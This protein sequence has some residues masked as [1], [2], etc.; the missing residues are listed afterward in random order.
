METCKYADGVLGPA[1]LV[2]NKRFKAQDMWV[3]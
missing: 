1:D 3:V 2:L